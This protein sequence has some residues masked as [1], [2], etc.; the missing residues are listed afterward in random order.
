[1][2]VTWL[3][4]FPVGQ[5]LRRPQVSGKDECEQENLTLT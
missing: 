2:A 5:N 1:M 4:N 3:G